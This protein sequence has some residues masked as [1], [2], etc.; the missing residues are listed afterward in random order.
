MHHR[1]RVAAAAYAAGAI[2]LLLALVATALA[3]ESTPTRP[4]S[5]VFQPVTVAAPSATPV[6]TSSPT[7]LF[8]GDFGASP[9]TMPSLP[10]ITAAARST[11]RPTPKPTPRATP[12]PTPKPAPRATPRPKPRVRT[13][14]KPAIPSVSTAK[15]YARSRIGSTQFSCL[16]KLF[17]RES[18]WRP[19]ARN[20]S[21]GAYGIPQAL[22]GD[23][24]AKMGSDW[25]DN[26]VTQV[27]WGLSYIAGR[28]GT[29]CRAW[30]HSQNHGWY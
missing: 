6:P 10:P 26:P 27:K 9:R 19:H 29:A 8:E 16:D 18:N 5:L 22:P 15:A 21:S 25:R 23:K 20:S 28:Y 7:T 12:K 2:V 13:V 24:M 30:Q 11:P 3:A 4:A 1:V 14:A 17:T